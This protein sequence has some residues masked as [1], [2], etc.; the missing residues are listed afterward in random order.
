MI[1]YLVGMFENIIGVFLGFFLGWCYEHHKNKT[2]R[3]NKATTIKKYSKKELQTICE[4][5][6]DYLEKKG[7][8]GST[9]QTPVLDILM[10]TGF[11]LDCLDEKEF[12]AY[13][14]LISDIEYLNAL[15]G[16]GSTNDEVVKSIIKSCEGMQNQ[17]GH[18]ESSG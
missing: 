1:E 5:L 10:N 4:G 6:T 7:S 16:R 18:H 8:F 14:D 11:M 9:I 3:K 12:N 13:M 17:E 2:D 15:I